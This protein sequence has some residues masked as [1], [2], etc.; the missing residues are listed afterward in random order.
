MMHLLLIF[1]LSLFCATAFAEWN[2][3]APNQEQAAAKELRRGLDL[4]RAEGNCDVFLGWTPE[5]RKRLPEIDPAALKPDEIIVKTFPDGAIFLAGEGADGTFYAVREFLEK[6]LG[7]RAF[8]PDVETVPQNPIREIPELDIRYAPPFFMRYPT[9]APLEGAGR[10]F[11]KRLRVNGMMPLG[12]A[13][14]MERFLPTEAFYNSHKDWYPPDYKFPGSKPEWYALREGRRIEGGAGQPCLTNAEAKAQIVK[15]AIAL[16]KHKGRNF[17]A[18]SLTQCDNQNFCLCPECRKK[19]TELGG[20]TDLMLWFVNGVAEEIEKEFPGLMVEMFAY[21]YTLEPPKTVKPRPNVQI[22]ICT[23]EAGSRAP[24][25]AQPRFR[26]ILEG[27]AKL[28]KNVAV[29]NYITNFTNYGLI[30]PNFRAYAENLRYFAR[31]GI[32]DVFTQDASPAGSFGFFPELRACLYAKLLWDP[33]LDPEQLEEEFLTACYG[34]AAP[35]LKAYLRLNEEALAQSGF[36]LDC[37][38]MDTAAWL[39]WP[40]LEQ[41]GKLLAEAAQAVED[42]PVVKKRVEYLRTS[43]DWTVLCRAELGPLSRL[44]PQKPDADI[45]ALRRNLKERLNAVPKIRQVSEGNSVDGGMQQLERRL[46]PLPEPGPVPRELRRF[47]ANRLLTLSPL[48]AQPAQAEFAADHL[49]ANREAMR[50]HLE[51]HNWALRLN[52][53][54]M[55]GAPPVEIYAELRLPQAVTAAKGVA[56]I[57]GLYEYGTNFAV[58]TALPIRAKLLSNSRYT[59]IKLG[60]TDFKCDRQLYF[61]GAGNASVPELLLGRVWLV[62]R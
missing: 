55:A 25:A 17:K 7:V 29:W 37:Y 41:G 15:N 32:R 22:R 44:L 56:V 21:Q 57:A 10:S 46:K 1:V 3:H 48:Y 53:P 27:W 40:V 2:I 36:P 9:S 16:V 50:L 11:A 42:D 31:L 24:L 33:E 49:A 62:R 60:E 6:A 58:K 12:F 19:A 52:L 34:K 39:P 13:H 51:N 43:H 26:E 23:I 54:A 30:H 59:V 5:I 28:T 45:A 20:Q 8:A 4:A 47:S 18:V 38:E 14:T 61:E 35:A